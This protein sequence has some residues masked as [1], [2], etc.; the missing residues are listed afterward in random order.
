MPFSTS[1]LSVSAQIVVWDNR[2]RLPKANASTG[3]HRIREKGSGLPFSRT[4]S[5]LSVGLPCLSIFVLSWIIANMSDTC[6]ELDNGTA[7]AHP[8]A[9]VCSGSGKTKTCC[10]PGM[11]ISTLLLVSQ[12]LTLLQIIFASLTASVALLARS[13]RAKPASISPFAPILTFQP[14]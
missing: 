3:D 8:L 5:Y 13:S 2:I 11:C 14:Q 7:N 1:A 12:M 10:S 9:V 6:Y 4:V